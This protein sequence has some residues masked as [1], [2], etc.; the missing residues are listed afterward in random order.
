MPVQAE[1]EGTWDA[2]LNLTLS[3]FDSGRISAATARAQAQAEAIRQQAIDLDRRIR[4]EVGSRLIERRTAETAVA[5][6]ERAVD[7]ARENEKVTRDRYREGVVGSSE[8]L[9]AEVR[10]L[11]AALDHTDA[12]A[13]LLLARANLER[14]VGSLR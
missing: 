4:L 10:N 12:Q 14:A 13:R 7:A 9:D 2:G 6:S 1:W 5:V 11:R 3:L 8:L